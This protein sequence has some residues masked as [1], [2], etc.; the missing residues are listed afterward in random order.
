VARFTVTFSGS[1]PGTA[2]DTSCTIDLTVDDEMAPSLP[3]NTD[4]CVGFCSFANSRSGGIASWTDADVM[5]S[6][7]SNERV[8]S[9]CSAR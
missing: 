3:I 8:S 9:P 7:V 5:P 2:D 1:N 4:A 6:M